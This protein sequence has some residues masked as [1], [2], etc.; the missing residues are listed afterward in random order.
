MSFSSNYLSVTHH[1]LHFFLSTRESA[2]I[3]FLL[4]YVPAIHS[5]FIP[6][7]SEA[8]NESYV[9]HVFLYLDML[10]LI[11]TIINTFGGLTSHHQSSYIEIYR[12][13]TSVPLHLNHVSAGKRPSK[14]LILLILVTYNAFIVTGVMFVY[15]YYL[16]EQENKCGKLWKINVG[17]PK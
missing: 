1:E 13:T 16:L 7:F 4:I 14:Q 9:C 6:D 3:D 5:Y 11:W 8:S 10:L 15:K 2:V 17:I 12:V